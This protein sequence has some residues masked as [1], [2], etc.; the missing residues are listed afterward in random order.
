MIAIFLRRG[1]SD[2]RLQSRGQRL[3][4]RPD[5]R[6]AVGLPV[7]LAQRKAHSRERA[8][9][10]GHWHQEAI[11]TGQTL[12][13]VHELLRRAGGRGCC[14]GSGYEPQVNAV[15]LRWIFYAERRATSLR[16]LH[17]GNCGEL[18]TTAGVRCDVQLPGGGRRRVFAG[19]NTIARVSTTTGST[20]CLE[21]GQ[22]QRSGGV[23]RNG[24]QS[25]RGVGC[26]DS[27]VQG[28]G[29]R[30]GAVMKTY[31]LLEGRGVG[32]YKGSTGQRIHRVPAVFGGP[33]QHGGAVGQRCYGSATQRAFLGCAVAVAGRC[34][35]TGSQRRRGGGG[36]DALECATG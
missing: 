25:T 22:G 36:M 16:R 12:Q 9:A 34:N 19:G 6:G 27:A 7:A 26:G 32:S 11:R 10:A 3:T 15:G 20:E 1:G 29:Q 31:Q 30:T 33:A 5:S 35:Q 24:G 28:G 4:E 2:R 14:A 21:V 8:P 17:I 13:K 18:R 23:A